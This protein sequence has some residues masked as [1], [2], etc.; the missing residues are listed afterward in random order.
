LLLQ[1]LKRLEN[2]NFGN[3]TVHRVVQG[4]RK[5]PYKNRGTGSSSFALKIV[6]LKLQVAIAALIS[7]ALVSSNLPQVRLG[8]AHEQSTLSGTLH[9]RILHT[10][11]AEGRRN[12]SNA[13]LTVD[14]VYRR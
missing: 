12:K 2:G 7:S 8:E 10:N 1:N 9:L 4:R 14:I 13:A 3:F 6:M 11:V 5:S